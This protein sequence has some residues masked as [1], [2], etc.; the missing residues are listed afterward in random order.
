MAGLNLLAQTAKLGGLVKKGTTK[1][2]SPK[3]ISAVKNQNVSSALQGASSWIDNALHVVKNTTDK[4]QTYGQALSTD[5]KFHGQ[6]LSDTPIYKRSWFKW[7]CIAMI[8]PVL[9]FAFYKI[10]KKRSSSRKY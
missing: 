8:L 9:I 2:L 4:V 3:F 6:V 10:T 5:L 7:V 1:I